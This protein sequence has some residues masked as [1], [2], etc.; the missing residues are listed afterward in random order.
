[1]PA[2]IALAPGQTLPSLDQVLRAPLLRVLGRNLVGRQ[3]IIDG[4]MSRVNGRRPRNLLGYWLAKSRAVLPEAEC[5]TR[6]YGP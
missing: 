3:V 6:T 4:L 2:P 1:M 5:V